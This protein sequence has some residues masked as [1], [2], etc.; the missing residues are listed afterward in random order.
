MELGAPQQVIDNLKRLD[1][2]TYQ[3]TDEMRSL[4]NM[5]MK[6][7]IVTEKYYSDALHIAIATVLSVDV[8]VSWNFKHI[9]NF[10]KIKLFNAV[11]MREGYNIL[12][13]RTPEEMINYE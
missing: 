4:A 8:L 7:K 6:E 5:Y 11:N 13:I 10:N 12:E 3:L 1:Y 2:E 9:V